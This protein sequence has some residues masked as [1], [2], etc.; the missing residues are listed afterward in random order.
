MTAELEQMDIENDFE[1]CLACF[2][3]WYGRR[4]DAYMASIMGILL[5]K[6]SFLAISPAEHA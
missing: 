1:G 4:E 5:R 6:L 2:E 3:K